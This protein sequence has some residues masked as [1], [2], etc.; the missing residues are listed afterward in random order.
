MNDYTQPSAFKHVDTVSQNAESLKFGKEMNNG[1]YK[2]EYV[3]DG[4]GEDFGAISG[5]GLEKGMLVLD[6]E[7]DS[8]DLASIANIVWN[9]RDQELASKDA[10]IAELE[11]QLHDP[12]LKYVLAYESGKSAGEAAVKCGEMQEVIEERDRY[13][14]ALE[15][16]DSDCG[17]V[18]W[19]LTLQELR[20]H[21]N[22]LGMN[23]MGSHEMP[24]HL[25][26]RIESIENMLSQMRDS[27]LA[28]VIPDLGGE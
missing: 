15:L 4:E 23:P 13:K 11:K 5:P 10:R 6:F 1:P 20:V 19:D 8:V 17:G 22:E 14:E 18:S 2:N 21:L 24:G 9:S 3:S 27:R 26:E 12:D 28:I 16:A 25:W 7:V